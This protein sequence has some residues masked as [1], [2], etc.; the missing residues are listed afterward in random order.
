MLKIIG[1]SLVASVLVATAGIATSVTAQVA[2]V[3][4]AAI[5]ADDSAK[6][7]KMMLVGDKAP[8]IHVEKFVKGEPVTS[9]EA[10]KVYVVEFWATWCGP[11]RAAFPHLSE[12]QK[13]Y[14]DKG[15]TFIGTNIWEPRD[16]KYTPE[17]FDK[18]SKFVDGQAEKM[19]Y[20]VAYD[21]GAKWMDQNYMQTTAQDGI[22]AAF[23]V[24]QEGRIAWLGHPMTMEDA[25]KD[26]V[27]KK[28]DIN[29]FAEKTNKSIKGTFKTRPM[30]EALGK[31]WQAK[32]W[33]EVE[34][35]VD[36]IAAISPEQ[37]MGPAMGYFSNVMKTDEAK[38]Y[39]F[40]A[41]MVDG[42]FKAEPQ[43]L[44]A[45]AWSIVDP[46]SEYAKKDLD[47]AM[48]AATAANEASK[49]KDAAIQDTLARVYWV[50]GNKAKAVEIQEKAIKN[51]TKEMKEDLEATLAEYKK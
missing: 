3:A 18:V 39:A 22:P 50:K 47:L 4:A 29:A 41:K 34:K 36:A 48:K 1:R 27:A 9:F 19:S 6:E 23:I 20:T 17:V 44:N 21:G 51:A 43:F 28:W 37:A 11:C 26:I 15:V 32:D 30:M 38:G 2:P 14:K 45:V 5:S 16:G 7:V 35:Q 42:P 49:D 10:G 31:A 24:D 40:A 25:L 33:P 8:G 13:E 12:M 46:D